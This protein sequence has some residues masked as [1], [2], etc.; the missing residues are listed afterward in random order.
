MFTDTL[1]Y[2]NNRIF[3]RRWLS[4]LS[5]ER[6]G[7]FRAPESP[8]CA[9]RAAL[10]PAHRTAG[11]PRQPIDTRPAFI[12]ILSFFSFFFF[13][14]L[15]HFLT[16]PREAAESTYYNFIPHSWGIRRRRFFRTQVLLHYRCSFL[17]SSIFF[18]SSFL[19][20]SSSRR[21]CP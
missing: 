16:V 10:R 13:T 14:V 12:I 11:G 15:A 17:P 18:L 20:V 9:E 5:S 19:S 21:R 8:S 7:A 3:P 6:S 2:V 4:S 1:L